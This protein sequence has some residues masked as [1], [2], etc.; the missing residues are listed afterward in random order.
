MPRG[1]LV[2]VVAALAA[3]GFSSCAAPPA[4]L[5]LDAID[6]TAAETAKAELLAARY[7]GGNPFDVRG[8]AFEHDIIVPG[9]RG[10]VYRTTVETR[11]GDKVTDTRIEIESASPRIPVERPVAAY[12]SM[13][14]KLND[15]FEAPGRFRVVGVFRDG[16][17]TAKALYEG[18]GLVE[19]RAA[20]GRGGRWG[21][22]SLD[23]R[24]QMRFQASLNLFQHDWPLIMWGNLPVLWCLEGHD[25]ARFAGRFEFMGREADSWLYPSPRRG[26]VVEM[27]FD[28]QTNLRLG[29]RIWRK[30]AL[31]W[32]VMEAVVTRHKITGGVVADQE[33]HLSYKGRRA[34]IVLL[35]AKLNPTFKETTF[36]VP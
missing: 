24:R 19:L 11:F 3:V 18:V 25:Q 5:A 14:D 30:G 10:S 31:G 17:A 27:L 4:P 7:V 36:T 16:R 32:D 22:Q 29:W 9:P 1:V 26:D 20:D 2:A 6:K 34:V 13:I 33:V 28:P 21:T 12:G 8:L 23:P 15:W 35:D